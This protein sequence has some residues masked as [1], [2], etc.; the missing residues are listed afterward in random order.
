MATQHAGEPLTPSSLI[1][2]TASPTTPILGLREISTGAADESHQHR[3][4]QTVAGW[5]S[6]MGMPPFRFEM[7]QTDDG[8]SGAARSGA[9]QQSA[10]QLTAGQGGG[11]ASR[12]RW[13][14]GEGGVHFLD[15]RTNV[16]IAQSAPPNVQG[17]LLVIGALR[18]GSLRIE[19]G[20]DDVTWLR[21]GEL[22]VSDYGRRMRM[23]WA[24]H[25]FL[26]LALPRKTVEAA[27]G[28]RADL[29]GRSVERLPD[30]GLSPLLWAQLCV[31]A[32]CGRGL[33]ADAW[34]TG[35]SASA[36]VALAVLRHRF[37]VR[38]GP[39][40]VSHLTRFMAARRHI[41]R[42]YH[43]P[44]LTAEH[45]ARAVACSRTQLY[46]AF[47][48]HGMSVADYLRDIRLN[49]A[50]ARLESGATHENL[51]AIADACGYTDLSAFGKAFKQRFG[52]PPSRWRRTT[53]GGGDWNDQSKNLVQSD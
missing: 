45:I 14:A 31:L 53:A 4:W 50:R 46:R 11:F 20:R 18:S 3:Y 30:A 29:G 41:E 1:P 35:L 7:P 15:G 12:L 6:A 22:F 51:A 5:G 9:H 48:A 10:G 17:D 49:R 39:N 26:F 2:P 40:D 38:S 47:A 34:A 33:D 28:R 37:D 42:H 8:T 19:H 52:E 13:C 21:A 44:N 43:Q 25:A 27:L 36:D 32:D 23:Q 16:T 24:P